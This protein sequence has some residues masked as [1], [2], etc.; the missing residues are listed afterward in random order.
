MAFPRVT[1]VC[2]ELGSNALGR[3]LLLARLLPPEARAE[4]VGLMSEPR[5]WPPARAAGVP[6]EALRVTHVCQLPAA[7]RWLRA[8]LRG[9]LVLI[10]KPLPTSLGLGL[11]ARRAGT[12]VALDVDD[13]EVGQSLPHDGSSPG[14]LR[15]AGS[16]VY[17]ALRRGQPNSMLGTWLCQG[18]VRRIPERLVS[19]RW[20]ERRFGGTL[21]YH[22]RDERELDPARVS[23]AALRTRLG[24]D[25]RTW[26]G[27]V[28]TVRVHKGLDDLIDALARL[29]GARA[30]GLLLLGTD[31]RDPVVNAV[32]ERALRRLG[33]ARVRVSGQFPM[34]RLAEHLQAA[35]VVAIPTRDMPASRGQTPAK[36]FDAM[37]MARPIVATALNDV[38][39]ILD[40]C[41][42]AVPPD[43][44]DALAAALE[45]LDAPERR[46]ALGAAARER[47]VERYSFRAGRRT[48]A[49]FVE[50]AMS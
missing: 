38:P 32:V 33:P 36:L 29:R 49:A 26:V 13:W 24:L 20:L 5:V 27:F 1:I 46:G 41:G 48:L 17:G 4:I 16:A 30:P 8:R 35:D 37:C 31:R 40:G 12:R 22:V 43:D 15:R 44:P 39:E 47:L 23:G 45:A 18:L 25:A 7:R 34:G 2:P 10:S 9:E 28:G 50:R 14:S 19:S 3:A 6:L 11:A 21:L 42:L